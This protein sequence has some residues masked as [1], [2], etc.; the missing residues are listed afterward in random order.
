[1]YHS[2]LIRAYTR[3]RQY[4]CFNATSATIRVVCWQPGPV[5]TARTARESSRVKTKRADCIAAPSPTPSGGYSHR[6]RYGGHSHPLKCGTCVGGP[7]VLLSKLLEMEAANDA[8]SAI[9][10]EIADGI[11]DGNSG[12]AIMLLKLRARLC[13]EVRCRVATRRVATCCKGCNVCLSRNSAVQVA[14]QC[15][16]L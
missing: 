2:V 13:K 9:A 10:S 14:T 12:E 1:L 4:E 8:P 5:R 16:T 3:D 15:T 6:I 11:A 7:P